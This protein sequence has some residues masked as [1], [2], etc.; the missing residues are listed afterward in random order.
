VT[1]HPLAQRAHVLFTMLTALEYRYARGPEP[2]LLAA[3]S[4]WLGGWPGIGRIVSG[5]SSTGLDVQ[6]T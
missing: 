5:R 1:A 6:L 3:P 2:P 4:T